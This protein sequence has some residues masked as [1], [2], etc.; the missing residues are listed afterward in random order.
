MIVSCEVKFSDPSKPEM[1]I[2]ATA[3]R[4]YLGLTEAKFL[5]F[6]KH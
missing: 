6:K 5:E 2:L 3:P 4:T 1:A